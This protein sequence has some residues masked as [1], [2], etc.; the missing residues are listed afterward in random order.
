MNSKKLASFVLRLVFAYISVTSVVE[1]PRGVTSSRT[2]LRGAMLGVKSSPSKTA[3]F[4]PSQHGLALPHHRALLEEV[5]T[6]ARKRA[7]P[8]PSPPK[9]PRSPKP[10]PRRR[11]SSPLPP[12]PPSPQAPS[13][14]A[15]SSSTLIAKSSDEVANLGSRVCG[16]VTLVSPRDEFGALKYTFGKQVS[17]DRMAQ[18]MAV[19]LTDAARK[20]GAQLLIPFALE[21]CSAAYDPSAS[22]PV[23]PAVTV[24]GSFVDLEEAAKIQDPLQPLLAQWRYL[25]LGRTVPGGDVPYFCPPPGYDIETM[26]WGEEDE[27]ESP[28]GYLNIEC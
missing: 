2:S 10:P 15:P 3:D 27:D 20:A 11:S 5:A 12:P 26:A 7:S 1:L 24:C 19:N 17:C 22:P 13:T 14:P 18:W 9:P 23:V 28:A 8:R 25:V 6:T 21:S 16:A 4:H